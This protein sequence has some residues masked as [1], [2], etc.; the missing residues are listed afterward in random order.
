MMMLPRAR[1]LFSCFLFLLMVDKHN[2]AL[3]EQSNAFGALF[4]GALFFVGQ[5]K[6]DAFGKHKFH[7]TEE[8]VEKPQKTTPKVG[9]NLNATLNNSG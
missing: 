2:F 7:D 9:L 8:V 1:A 4:F 5:G 3:G 6:I